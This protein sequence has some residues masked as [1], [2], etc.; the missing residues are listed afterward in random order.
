[1]NL[2]TQFSHDK[3]M[4]DERLMLQKKFGNSPKRIELVPEGNVL[5]KGEE[6]WIPQVE[7]GKE[8]DARV[9]S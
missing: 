5:P 8:W 2:V 9:G 7:H 1:M 3:K 6:N 4:E